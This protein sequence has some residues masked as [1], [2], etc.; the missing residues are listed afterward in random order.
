MG[1][2]F[3]YFVFEKNQ[4]GG[5]ELRLVDEDGERGFEG[6]FGCCEIYVVVCVCPRG[7]HDFSR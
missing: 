3:S 7:R 5:W 4:I 1:V 2:P 6:V